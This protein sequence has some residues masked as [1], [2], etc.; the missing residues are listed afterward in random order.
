MASHAFVDDRDAGRSSVCLAPG[1]PDEDGDLRIHEIVNLKLDG[2]LVVLAS[3]DSAAGPTL[4]GEGVMSLVRAFF[5][6]GARAVVASLESLGDDEAKD[7]FIRFHD[8]LAAGRSAAAALRA[9]KQEI[10][11]DEG[12]SAAYASSAWSHVV[13]YG[14]GSLRPLHAGPAASVHSSWLLWAAGV[15]VIYL[16]SIGVRI[17]LRRR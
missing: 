14:D 13:L 5:L 17:W 10:Y 7:L 8:H 4:A 9:A 15:L 12:Q 2:Q 16:I 3:C 11:A 6:A 1:S